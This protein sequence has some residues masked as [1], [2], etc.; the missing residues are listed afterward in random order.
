MDRCPTCHRKHKR[1]NPANALLWALYHAMAE[2]DWNGQR[3]SA[4]SFHAYYKQRFLGADDVL[5]PNGKTLTIPRSTA[6]LD[7]DEFSDYLAKVEADA[8]ERG[9]FLSELAA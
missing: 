7:A 9:V 3:Y 5:L 4:E 6:N 1:S 2:R 8:A